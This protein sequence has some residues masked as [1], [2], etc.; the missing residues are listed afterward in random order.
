MC[1]YVPYGVLSRRAGLDKCGKEKLS[2]SL[3]RS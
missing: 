3:F 2:F 1:T